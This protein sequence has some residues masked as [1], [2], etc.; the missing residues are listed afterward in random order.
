MCYIIT[1]YATSLYFHIL[2]ASNLGTFSG[3]GTNVEVTGSIL[4][5]SWSSDHSSSD[6]GFSCTVQSG[7]TVR[8]GG[9]GGGRSSVSLIGGVGW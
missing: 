4:Y 1:I 7:I 6:R 2:A 8:N 5:I 3:C 9:G